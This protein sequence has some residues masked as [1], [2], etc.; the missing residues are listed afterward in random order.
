MS[1]KRPSKPSKPF[2]TFPLTPHNNGQ[3]CKKIRGKIHFFGVWNEPQAA[4][5]RYL[6]VAADLHAGR[7]IHASNLTPA[8]LTVK[9]LGNEFLAY[10][11]ERVQSGQI[12]G[13]WF[14]DCRRVIVHFAKTVGK[15]RMANGLAMTDFQRYR[16]KLVRSGLTGERGL[17]VHAL[18]RALA[19]ISAMF[20]WA[21]DGG[22]LDKLPKWGKAMRKPSAVEKRKSRQAHEIAN[23][24]RL[25]SSTEVQA[26][27]DNAT[28]P[29]LRAAILLGI[30]GG[31]GNTD[32]AQL[33]KVAIDLQASVIDFDRPKTAVRRTVP[34]WPETM[35]ALEGILH[36][37]RPKPV[38]EDAGQLVFLTETGRAL[39]RNR[40]NVMDD[41]TTKVS[42]ADRL[43]PWFDSLLQSL[44]LKRPGFG[45]YTL[46]HTF[47]TWADESRDQ[48]AIHRIMGHSLPGMSGV[49]VEE[50][51]V[52]RLRAVVDHVRTQFNS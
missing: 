10:Q 16:T 41:G 11:L 29:M 43:R 8:E 34:L 38:D 37:D 7:E 28:N 44:G 45:F 25:F 42:Y 9:K 2:P 19:V 18:T 4:H 51:S 39:V 40:I 21:I 49:Y 31:F 23:G 20:T 46:R 52:E 17:G 48:H 15:L 24:K 32:C 30:N 26:L 12:S 47:R 36:G 6:A 27:I 14:E 35:T 33:P 1:S 13:R 5:D 50:I 22:Y 3:W